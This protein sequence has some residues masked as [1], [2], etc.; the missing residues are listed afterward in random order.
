M[1]LTKEVKNDQYEIVTDYKH[2]QVRQAT[3]VSEDGKELSRSFH[4]KVL[5][6]DMD[7]SGEDAEVQRLAS[8]LWTDEAKQ[9]WS[10]FQ[11]AQ[12]AEMGG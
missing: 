1:A 10:D 4:R 12:A 6:P 9:A 8:A 3:I 7:V 11:D 5:S 2:I